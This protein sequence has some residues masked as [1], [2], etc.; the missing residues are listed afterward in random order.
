M[1]KNL[2][3]KQNIRL[4]FLLIIIA[5][6]LILQYYINYFLT[7]YITKKINKVHIKSSFQRNKSIDTFMN[8]A[9]T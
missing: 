4:I 3:K 2:K 9:I 1:L 6:S 7:N 5:E 8:Y